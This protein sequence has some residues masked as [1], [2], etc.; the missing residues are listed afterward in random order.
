MKSK[1][2]YISETSDKGIGITSK[3]IAMAGFT[4]VGTSY[5]KKHFFTVNY[6]L[7]NFFENISTENTV[8]DFIKSIAKLILYRATSK[9]IL[10]TVHNKCPHDKR[11]NLNIVLMKIL[12][13]ASYKIII[14]CDETRN[15]LNQL[16]PFPHSKFQHKII[17]IPHPNYIGHY[18]SASNDHKHITNPDSV[19]FLFLG[20]IRPYKNIDIL[21]EAFRGINAARP[22]PMNA[23]LT[24]RGICHDNTLKTKLEN[25]CGDDKK[26]TF[27][28]NYV[29]DNDIL[30]LIQKYDILI[31]PYDLTSSLNSGVIFL[32]FSCKR[33][34]I[35]PLIGTLKEYQDKSFFYSYEY[36]SP[37]KHIQKLQENINQV[38]VDVKTNPNSLLE[39]GE[40]AFLLVEKNNSIEKIKNLFETI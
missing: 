26:I 28:T 38:L 21:I 15:V 29:D 17:K 1:T 25:M 10:W 40:K 30:D 12:L 31:L 3:A 34:V 19:Q 9:K 22:F 4:V 11:S 32:S 13:I 5:F 35:S 27:N 20:G 18:R 14:M 2:I 6:L 8:K 16:P 33:T 23:E 36:T 24:I 7:F 37:E 39:K